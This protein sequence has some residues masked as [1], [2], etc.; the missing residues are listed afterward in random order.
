MNK[1]KQRKT[2][3]K[4]GDT[5]FTSGAFLGSMAVPAKVVKIEKNKLVYAKPLIKSNIS[6][7]FC[8][9]HLD[10]FTKDEILELKPEL[11]DTMP[12]FFKDDDEESKINKKKKCCKKYNTNFC[13]ECGAKILN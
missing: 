13:P 2:V 9:T 11:K 8:G 5:V 10:F 7:N 4:L 1:T 12:E 6:G 3:H